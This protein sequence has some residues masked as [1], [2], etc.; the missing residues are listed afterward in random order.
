MGLFLLPLSVTP[1]AFVMAKALTWFTETSWPVAK[2][3]PLPLMLSMNL[4]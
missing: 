4:I 1:N 3:R 2:R